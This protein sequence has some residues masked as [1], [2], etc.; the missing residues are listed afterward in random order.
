MKFSFPDPTQL[1]GVK[2][3]TKSILKMKGITF[4]YPTR[5][6]PTIMDVNLECS[7]ASR[8][9]VIGANG[10]GK[11]TAIKILIGELKPEVGEIYKHPNLRLAYIAQHAF[12]HLEKHI[13]KTA[14]QYILWRFAGNEDKEN[15]ELLHQDNNEDE[16]VV[17]KK[18]MINP[19]DLTALKECFGEDEDKKAVEVEKVLNRREN[20]KG[21][22]TY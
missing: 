1:E 4:T 19:N 12:H 13:N 11:S 9:A 2:S 10:A 15:V 14:T 16:D 8:V 5:D 18:Y 22:T 6:K 17:K 20:K 7:R 21:V 3:I